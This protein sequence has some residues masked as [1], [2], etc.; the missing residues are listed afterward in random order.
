MSRNLYHKIGTDILAMTESGATQPNPRAS[1]Q[2]RTQ[3]GE[4]RGPQAGKHMKAKTFDK[5]I[6]DGFNLR[7]GG[8]GRK[9]AESHRMY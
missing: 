8:G 2:H 4:C 5:S 7:P 6:A 3:L 1:Y 9:L